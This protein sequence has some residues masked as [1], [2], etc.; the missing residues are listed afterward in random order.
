MYTLSPI[1][2][3]A[4]EVKGLSLWEPQDELTIARLDDVWSR[5]G[6][7]VFR[8]QVLSET[9]LMDFSRSLGDPDVIVREDWS[10]S[11]TPEVI[12]ISNMKNYHG[13]SIG[14][15]GVGELDW[16]TDQSLSLIHI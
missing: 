13:Q 10:S 16:H 9:E 15:L 4:K 7:L 6:V 5:H 11:H 12:Q 3:F 14:G 8:R 1:G 2:A